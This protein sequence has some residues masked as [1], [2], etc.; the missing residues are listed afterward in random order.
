MI[1]A[2]TRAEVREAE[3]R[4][5]RAAHA[6]GDPDRLMR[7]A[8]RAVA[9][10]VRDLL[11]GN[12]PASPD[13]EAG[14]RVCALVGGGDNGGDALYAASFLAEQ[15]V[16]CAA[17]CL[18]SR[19][20]ERAR[21]AAEEQGVVCLPA[22]LPAEDEPLG[23]SRELAEALDAPI[24][25]DGICGTGLVG[26]LREPLASRLRELEGIRS[27]R[28][29]RV[30]A[31]D[32]P[33]GQ[34]GDDGEVEGPL[35][36]A[37]RTV[38]MGAMKSVLA[39]PPAS[40]AAGRVRVHGLGLDMGRSRVILMEEADV[41]GLIRVPGPDD[42]KYTRGVVGLVA[43]S[44]TYPGAGVLAVLGAQGAGPGMV[45]L[46]APTR[47]AD[48]AL[49]AAPGV[50]TRGGR[51]QAGLV[52]PGMDEDTRQAARELAGFAAS[53]G[54]PLIIDAG[55]LELVPDL[56]DEGIGEFTVLTPHAGE[57]AALLGALGRAAPR[58]RVEEHP[59]E[60]ARALAQASG[61]R[62]LLKGATTLL[63]TPDSRVL[64]APQGSA[65]TG[66]AG[67]GDVLA[68]FLAGLAA[69]WKADRERGLPDRDFDALIAAGA[70]IHALAG[71]D[72]ARV[73]GP[74]GG[75]IGA[76]DIA[77]ALPSVLARLL[78]ESAGRADPVRY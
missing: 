36:K 57:A 59:A 35:L 32:A 51:I 13:G 31:I 25:I 30:V 71:A 12:P 17:V 11:A 5:V 73:H 22:H 48:L 10:E 19:V 37:E 39:L 6:E 54:L 41:P 9:D 72:A 67:A 2:F 27:E 24:W 44:Q 76:L 46:D 55:G 3:A 64:V 60:A 4:R 65:W 53:S 43:G 50:V 63:A 75:P 18:S 58:W 61:A 49:A 15:G 68:G 26:G 69:G 21:A 34:L 52:G 77:R 40:R 45:R 62:V 20:H 8:S 74:L 70:M 28:G 47:V 1:P 42:H 16:P 23:S 78:A 29:A 38:T 14:P 33:S 7:S 56:R 66:V